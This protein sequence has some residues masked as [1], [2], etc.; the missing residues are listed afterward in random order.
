MILAIHFF[1]EIFIMYIEGFYR[2]VSDATTFLNNN[3]VGC[4]LKDCCYYHSI[5]LFLNS[6]WNKYKTTVNKL[7]IKNCIVDVQDI[8]KR[9][10]PIISILYSLLNHSG[11]DKTL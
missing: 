2:Q 1:S 10:A 9:S 8:N 4:F 3:K 5:Y 7:R 11:L 6:L